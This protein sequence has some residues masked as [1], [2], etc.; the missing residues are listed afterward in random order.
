[1][2]WLLLLIPAAVA[3][4]VIARHKAK[5][6]G[7]DF[8]Q[9]IKKMPEGAPP[10]WAYENVTAVRKNTERIIELLEKPKEP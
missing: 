7:L 9:M 6:G 1:M 5:T 8:E 10:R 4:A 2:K 3:A